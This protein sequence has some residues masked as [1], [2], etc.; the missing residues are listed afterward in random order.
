MSSNKRRPQ[1]SEIDVPERY[2]VQFLGFVEH[3]V[4]TECGRKVKWRVRSTYRCA[5]GQHIIQ[6]LR[7]P[8]PGCDGRAK[9]L[10]DVPD[11]DE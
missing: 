10:T 2:E 9:R 6:Y 11:A 7:C 5:D 8:T 4:C 3:A 1:T